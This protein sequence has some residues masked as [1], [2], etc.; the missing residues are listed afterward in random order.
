MVKVF[1]VHDR[2]IGKV[3]SNKGLQGVVTKVFELNGGTRYHVHYD[4]GK[5]ETETKTSMDIYSNCQPNTVRETELPENSAPP[6]TSVTSSRSY[7]DEWDEYLSSDDDEPPV[8]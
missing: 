2:V 4:N 7:A 8:R 6:S 5:T 3:K 1:K